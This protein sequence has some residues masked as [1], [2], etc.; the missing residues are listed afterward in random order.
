MINNITSLSGYIQ[1]VSERVQTFG[2]SN[3]TTTPWFR[4]QSDFNWK[5]IPHIHRITG[6]GGYERDL[7]RDF[8]L[9]SHNILQQ[10]KLENEFDWLYVMQHYGLPTRLLDWTESSLVALF[11]AVQDFQYETNAAV[12]VF[13]PRLF[14]LMIL[15]VTNTVPTSDY[16]D[17]EKYIITRPDF[18]EREVKAKLPIALRPS[19][20]SPR[21]LAQ[22]GVFTIHGN[23]PKCINDIVNE[24]NINAYPI[25]ER[26]VIDGKSKL[27]LLKELYLSGISH[28]VIFPE[29]IGI[30]Q[31]LR[32]RYSIDF[33]G[34]DNWEFPFENNLSNFNG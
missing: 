10:H 28:S 18:A 17:L 21:I 30:T 6:L 13:S 23:L 29:L 9:L 1:T 3:S 26:I 4:G 27:K 7:I 20:N 8:K 25:L 2:L 22:R 24:M 11:F 33:L 16:P 15:K 19:M 34:K 12:W 31:E 14:N 5:L 32:H